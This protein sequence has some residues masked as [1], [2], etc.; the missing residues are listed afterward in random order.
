M[1]KSAGMMCMLS[2][3]FQPHYIQYNEKGKDEG[4]HGHAN[5]L[6]TDHRKPILPFTGGGRERNGNRSP[7]RQPRC[8]YL[9]SRFLQLLRHPQRPCQQ[10]QQKS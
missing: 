4:K 1:P 6:V 9:P 7:C 5:A 2:V 3:L 8:C 10:Q